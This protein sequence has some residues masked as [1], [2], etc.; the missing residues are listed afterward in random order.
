MYYFGEVV[1]CEDSDTSFTNVNLISPTHSFYDVLVC[2]HRPTQSCTC[3]WKLSLLCAFE[4]LTLLDFPR[5]AEADR[6][7]LDWSP[8][9]SWDSGDQFWWI[10]RGCGFSF[11]TLM[12]NWEIDFVELAIRVFNIFFTS[13]KLEFVIISWGYWSIWSGI[14]FVRFPE[15]KNISELPEIFQCCT[16][17]ADAWRSIR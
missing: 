10:L 8:I 15:V 9:G 5:F 2:M 17:L 12:W 14:G 11:F 6:R 4:S 3:T 13:W 1:N 7:C 16:Y